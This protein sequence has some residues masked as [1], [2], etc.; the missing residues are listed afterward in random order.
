VGC[1]QSGRL[2]P[3]RSDLTL[4]KVIQSG[5]GHSSVLTVTT[6]TQ[7][8]NIAFFTWESVY[9]LSQLLLVAFAGLALVSGRIVNNR[10]ATQLVTL[11]TQLAT[12]KRTQAEAEKSLLELQQ[13]IREPRKIDEKRANEILDWSSVGS[14]EIIFLSAGN[15]P[16]KLAHS[17][18][19]ILSAHG[20]TILGVNAALIAEGL[21]PG[22]EFRINGADISDK[23]DEWPQSAQRLYRLLTEAVTGNSHVETIVDRQSLKSP[24][25]VLTICTKY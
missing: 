9:W 5:N 13:L 15:E 12:A 3:R 24:P 1:L 23:R 17:L 14:V 25:L 18:A 2:E 22:I 8:M 21:P 20:W 11:E 19:N 4:I 16:G 6:M 7:T 10:Q